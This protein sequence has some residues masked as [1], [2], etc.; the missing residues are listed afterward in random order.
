MLTPRLKRKQ[1]SQSMATVAVLVVLP[2][3][4]TRKKDKQ[5][6]LQILNKMV[7]AL[8]MEVP[9]ARTTKVAS[10]SRQVQ[11]ETKKL[12][13]TKIAVL[14]RNSQVLVA[15]KKAAA[16]E[17]TAAATEITAAAT[18]ALLKGNSLLHR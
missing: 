4:I 11:V 3:P 2:M 14:I 10:K 17:T 5:I 12:I 16:T 8:Q 7:K 18:T 15:T 1:K 9:L 13:T 6:L